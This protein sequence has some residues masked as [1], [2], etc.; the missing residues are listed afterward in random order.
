MV[1]GLAQ[2]LGVNTEGLKKT[3]RRFN[4]FS[5]VGKDQEFGRGE[6][7]FADSVTGDLTHQPNPNLGPLSEP[8]YYGLPLEPAATSST[9][10]MTNEFGQ[11]LHLRGQAIPGLYACGS[12]SAHF[13]GIG[14]QAACELGGAMTFGYLAARHAAAA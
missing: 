10:L 6:F 8:P 11:V 14:Y 9:G 3:I 12:T 2:G 1:T 5:S 13:Y 7:P 4:R